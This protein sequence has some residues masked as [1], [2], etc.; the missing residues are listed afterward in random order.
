MAIIGILIALLLPAVQAAREA[1]RRMQCTNNLKQ[2]GLA[3]HN[4]HD[5]MKGLPP[6]TVGGGLGNASP[7]SPRVTFWGLILPYIEQTAMY[8]MLKTKTNNFVTLTSNQDFWNPLSL[9]ER[10]SVASS[11]QP[12]RCPSRRNKAA[13]LGDGPVLTDPQSGQHGPQG[14][15][16]FGQGQALVVWPQWTITYDPTNIWNQRGPIR[17]PTWGGADASSWTPRDNM[18]YWTDGTSNQFVI[19][20][21]YIP[22]RF[23]GVCS[24]A[25]EAAKRWENTDCSQ[26]A[27]GGIST[28]ATAG[29]FN[30]YFARGVD[31]GVFSGNPSPGSESQSTP[32]WG[33][34]HTSV[35][36]FLFGDG[37]VQAISITTPTGPLYTSQANLDN[38]VTTNSILARLG[39]VNDGNPVSIP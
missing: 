20:E 5:A 34:N 4:F 18:G 6:A 13:A 9:E 29:S 21:K 7:F 17:N 12:F 31:D 19:G 23:V 10:N 8:D 3:V 16:A 14:D 33:S 2:M 27:I 26:L 11:W 22:A 37:S 30:G 32:H 1:A 25:P 24:E 35:V 39:C 38:R 15:Y 36:N 28:F